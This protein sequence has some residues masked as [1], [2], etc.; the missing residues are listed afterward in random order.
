MKTNTDSFYT[1]VVGVTFKNPN[2]SSRQDAIRR[3]CLPGLD[4]ILEREPNN[5]KDP[6]TILVSVPTKLARPAKVQIGQ[7]SH[8]LA[9]KLAPHMD[10]GEILKAR[11]T[12]MTGG[13]PEKK[14]V[15][16]NIQIQ[17][18]SNQPTQSTI[19]KPIPKKPSSSKGL[20]I[21][22]IALLFLLVALFCCCAGFFSSS[23]VYYG[24]EGL[25]K[26]AITQIIV[27]Q[28]VVKYP[29]ST[30]YPTYTPFPT[31]TNF[32][33]LP[34]YTP[35]PTSEPITNT[36]TSQPQ[37][38]SYPAG[39]VITFEDHT[40]VL[41]SSNIDGNLLKVNFTAQNTGAVPFTISS[42]GNFT[43][44][45]QDGASLKQVIVGCSDSSLNGT[46]PPNDLITGDICYEGPFEGPINIYYMPNMFG[47]IIITWEITL[48]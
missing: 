29:P 38:A 32:P 13:T 33:P 16:V 37:A 41:N 24:S 15:G 43:A 11:I 18:S 26:K 20:N 9:N 44:R 8:H 39:E 2:G 35:F 6:N 1:K 45:R 36:S 23:F 40:L 30:S 34:T 5:L 25:P 17:K 21:L 14:A 10:R 47:S 12:E 19:L 22:I 7:L 46:I 42:M 27:T 3:F 28:N 4:L 31:Y 48:P